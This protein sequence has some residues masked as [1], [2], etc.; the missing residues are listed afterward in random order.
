MKMMIK[1]RM[2]ICG[3][4]NDVEKKQ[5]CCREAETIRIGG[6]RKGLASEKAQS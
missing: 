6:S 4:L 1:L 2:W 3:V 5:K